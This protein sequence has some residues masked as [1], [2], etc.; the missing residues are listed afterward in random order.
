MIQIFLMRHAHYSPIPGKSH[1]ECPIDTIGQSQCAEVAKQIKQLG[2]NFNIGFCSDLQRGQDTLAQLQSNGVNFGTLKT[3]AYN[4]Y[5]HTSAI[6]SLLKSE[7]ADNQTV[8]WVGHNPNLE[9]L[10]YDLTG[11]DLFFDHCKGVLLNFEE[12]IK[13]PKGINIT[14]IQP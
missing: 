13:P 3:Y 4:Q 9:T 8:L 1:S 11:E 14:V 5:I 7:V 6:L 10:Y 12:G 2:L